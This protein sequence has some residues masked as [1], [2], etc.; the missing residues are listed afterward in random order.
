MDENNK[1]N[2]PKETT[3]DVPLE[4][5][6]TTDIIRRCGRN[7]MSEIAVFNVLRAYK[8]YYIANDAYVKIR[9]RQPCEETTAYQMGLADRDMMIGECVARNLQDGTKTAVAD[10][11]E[12]QK[13]QRIRAAL[14]DL[15]NS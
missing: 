4:E 13:H 15:N 7:G 11:L 9:S 5:L 14:D 12:F 3:Q 2:E 10:A 1:H 6:S 8:N